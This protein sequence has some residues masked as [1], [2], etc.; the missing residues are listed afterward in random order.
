MQMDEEE[1]K[2]VEALQA[3]IEEK[4]KLF[5]YLFTTYANSGPSVGKRYGSFD[6]MGTKLE[7]ITVPELGRMFKD[8]NVS[9]K[10]LSPIE[11]FHDSC[12]VSSP[13]LCGC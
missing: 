12:I 5:R 4:K 8:H 10:M 3:L 11:V 13:H 1:E 6:T 9:Q 2:D 7:T